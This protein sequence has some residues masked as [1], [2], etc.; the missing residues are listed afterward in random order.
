MAMVTHVRILFMAKDTHVRVLLMA[1][2]THVKTTHPLN[3]NVD[4]YSPN[5]AVSCR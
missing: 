3:Y 2:D 4:L 1:K 5:V